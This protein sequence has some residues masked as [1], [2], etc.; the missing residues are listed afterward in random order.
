MES[1]LVHGGHQS[2]LFDIAFWQAGSVGFLAENASLPRDFSR[3]P[4]A[5]TLER[6]PLFSSISDMFDRISRFFMGYIDH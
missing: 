1:I 4:G 5:C 2:R 6:R 3:N